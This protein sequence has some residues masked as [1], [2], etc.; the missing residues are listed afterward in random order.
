MTYRPFP[1]SF[2][3]YYF[4]I[5]SIPKLFS[6]LVLRVKRTAIG[7]SIISSELWDDLII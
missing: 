4:E 2:W 5:E 6:A 7:D 3:A 1:S